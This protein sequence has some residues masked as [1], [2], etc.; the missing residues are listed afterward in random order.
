MWYIS[1]VRVI[2]HLK[3]FVA[4]ILISLA[5]AGLDNIHF[6]TFPKTLFSYIINPISFG[7][8]QTKQQV[9]EQ[10]FFLT[11]ARTAA[12]E[13][14]ALKE[15]LGYLLSE[16]ASIRTKLAEV[17]S[18]L[19][20]ETSINPA[21]YNLIPA[22][23]V[24]LDRFLFIDKGSSSGVKLGQAV[25]FKDSYVGQVVRVTERGAAIRLSTDPDT[26]LSAFS[27]GGAGK[28]KGVL[29]GQYGSDMLL[30]KILHQEPIEI[31]NLVYSEGLELFLP[32]GL[33]LG[34]VVEV[35]KKETAVFKSAKV[36]PVFDV[37][38]LDLVFVIGD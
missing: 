5:I 26:K 10:I 34:T 4:L 27:A 21:T 24:G 13:N 9:S 1:Q 31:G 15:Q 17:E 30:D 28:A 22:R 33:V 20:Q 18:L 6:L 38:D 37:G 19:Q 25:L 32:R 12:K 23:P 2:P 36:A 3:L 29:L 11:S 7:F 8:Y 16:N 14:K 35:E